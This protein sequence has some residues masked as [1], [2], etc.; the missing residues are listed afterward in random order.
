M[1]LL[2][3][4]FFAGILAL[5]G[6]WLL[7]RFNRE[8]PPETA[9]P[10]TRFLEATRVPVSRQKKLR[11]LGLFSLRTLFLLALCLLFAQPYCSTDQNRT[12]Q[13]N[14][15]V[16]IDRS[17][18]MQTGDRWSRAVA[19]AS[20]A[21]SDGR[22]SA[23]SAAQGELNSV[24]LFDL[25]SELKAHGELSTDLSA[26]NNA[27]NNLTP[28]FE[29]GRYG[30]M[31]QQLDALASR[32]ELPVDVVFITDAQRS[33]LPLQRRRLRTT[34][35]D[36]LSITNVAENEQNLAVRASASSIDGV[37]VSV[38]AQVLLSAAGRNS[39]ES[40]TSQGAN[41]VIIAEGRALASEAL[42]LQV[43]EPISVVINELILPSTE[44]KQ[45]NVRVTA[46]DGT[47]LL[48]IDNAI[49]VAVQRAE[50]IAVGVRALGMQEPEDAS[51]FLRT[52][53]TTDRL[54]TLVPFTGD[55]TT[56]SSD[57]LHWVVFV[58]HDGAT[59]IEVPDSVESFVEEGGNVLLVLQPS[60]NES[61]AALSKSP[62]GLTYGLADGV[63]DGVADG[64]ADSVA[65]GPAGGA[66]YVG[67]VDVA[68]PLALG[69]LDWRETNVYS[70]L[71]LAPESIDRVLMRTGQGVPLMIERNLFSNSQ[72]GGNTKHGRLLIVT[73]PLDGVASDIPLQSS[74]VDWVAQIVGWFDAS[75]A[76][77]AQLNA[78]DSV[79]LPANAQVIAP[80]GEALRSLSGSAVASRVVLRNPGVHTVVT[81]VAEH[82]IAIT[83]PWEESNLETL[84]EDYLAEWSSGEVSETDLT[85][86]D[87]LANND[88]LSSEGASNSVRTPLPRVSV[89]WPWL[90]S[91]LALSLVAESLLAN[92]RLAVRR[93]GV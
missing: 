79:A 39:A 20:S 38:S 2:A 19:E 40:L 68:H 87:T 73:D 55:A 30:V 49:D 81:S 89:W 47:D 78:G 69:E 90:L 43:N 67:T 21:L 12:A 48:S 7:H 32:E 10:S 46:D 61:S 62:E 72:A 37:N 22:T 28:S 16:V 71:T 83:V 50:P 34:N 53:L 44:T 60:S 74:F 25:T 14:T 65:V 13:R 27:L 80:D 45:L 42:V 66:D 56:L 15:Y 64:L 70:T 52:A 92:R 59:D 11:H 77:P 35:I 5:L 36:Q 86:S 33:N 41:L 26:P 85:A 18:S 23:Q 63:A 93:D 3:P 17:A 4:L 58:P 91:L 84:S 31:M 54:A 75:I 51:L 57:A 24:Q 82:A 9:F 88:E 8:D 6:P 76:F 29:Q 1:S